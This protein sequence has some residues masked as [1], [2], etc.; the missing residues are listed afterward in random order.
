MP[1]MENHTFGS[2]FIKLNIFVMFI[3]FTI[4]NQCDI[5][6]AGE[7][8]SRETKKVLVDNVEEVWKLQWQSKPEEVCMPKDTNKLGDGGP[9]GW[10]GP[11]NCGC[12]IGYS[13]RDKILFLTRERNGKV[14][15]EIS[16]PSLG[17]E[18][19]DLLNAP[20]PL[21]TWPKDGGD[22]KRYEK[23]P[24]AQFRKE[25]LA[26]QKVEIMDLKDYDHDGWTTEFVMYLGWGGVCGYD[27]F[28]LIGLTR[29]NP[30]LHVFGTVTNPNKPLIMRSKQEW[31]ELLTAKAGEK[32][33]INYWSCG[34]HGAEEQEV[35]EFTIGKNGINADKVWLDCATKKE[36]K[37]RAL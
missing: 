28:A 32:V 18:P 7:R 3:L 10:E 16:V 5:S 14:I 19:D 9:G 13:E 34:D 36:I 21:P 20:P 11:F 24:Q 31:N 23:I 29:R 4:S 8:W 27:H 33:R 26:R 17:E 15:D 1:K 2:R 25:I 6:Y 35:Y 37:R 12:A 30:R 22:Y